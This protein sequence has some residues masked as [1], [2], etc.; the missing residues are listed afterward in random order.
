MSLK[1][2]W[3]KHFS[4]YKK[5]LSQWFLRNEN[6]ELEAQRVHAFGLG[7][8]HGVMMHRKEYDEVVDWASEH[9]EDVESKTH[10]YELGYF[11]TNRLKWVGATVLGTSYF[12]GGLI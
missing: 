5:P 1:K 2:T 11:T 10:Y 4:D 6:G 3:D 12:M 7:L 9:H 8:K